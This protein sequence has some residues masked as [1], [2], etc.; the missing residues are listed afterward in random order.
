MVSKEYQE[1]AKALLELKKKDEIDG[2]DD[3]SDDATQ[4]NKDTNDNVE[5]A[6]MRFVAGTLDNGGPSPKK[7]GKRRKSFTDSDEINQFEHWN[8]FLITDQQG[9]EDSSKSNKKKRKHHRQDGSSM[10][11]DP[12]LTNLVD[13]TDHEQLVRDAIMDA[14]QLAGDVNIHDYIQHPQDDTNSLESDLVQAAQAAQAVAAAVAAQ[15]EEEKNKKHDEEN[16]RP[17]KHQSK[18]KLPAHVH[19]S[20][21]SPASD[22]MRS[23]TSTPLQTGAP[24]GSLQATEQAAALVA[25]AVDR[26]AVQHKNQGKM[27]SPEEI[28]AIDSF[29]VDYGRINGMSRR[30]ICERVWSNGRK[31][32]DFWDCVHR[33]L[34]YRTRASVYKHVR[35]AYHVFDVRGKWSP[36][37]DEQ[38]ARLA[39]EKDGQWKAIGLVMGR[40]PEDCRDRWRNYV[41]CGQQRA[42]NK[43]TEEEE[44]RMR[45]IIEDMIAMQPD[46]MNPVINWTVVSEQMEGK[47][48]RIQCRY[49]WNKLMKRDASLR[50]QNIPFTDRV[51]MLNKLQEL[52][53]DPQDDVNWEALASLHPKN[54]WTANDFKTCY[55]K[56][57]ATVKDQKKKSMSEIS[58]A[59]L[60]GLVQESDDE[61]AELPV[62]FYHAKDAN[63]SG[64]TSGSNST[65]HP[66]RS[67]QATA[68]APPSTASDVPRGQ[69]PPTNS[70]IWP[71]A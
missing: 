52:S 50:A 7:N 18:K 24:H 5:A 62:V 56:M 64:Q 13:T 38:L 44:L 17:S 51:W 32:D 65:T 60:Q 4:H 66:Q 6:V 25:Q 1:G 14:N 53:F 70:Y 36:E 11:V 30:D 69:N 2:V 8:Q 41:K 29:I 33:V 16:R 22:Q 15:E 40:M 10:Q 45:R 47:R 28:K 31:K 34:P 3:D 37:E 42:Q 57:K 35:R 39:A 49:K 48:S 20:E 9:D 68:T 71:S 58:H 46:S 19:L 12:E 61:S 67:S 23:S 43:W 55:E 21:A 26:A 54:E 27:F 63:A 59:L